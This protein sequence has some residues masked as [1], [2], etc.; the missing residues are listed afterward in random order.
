MFVSEN[1]CHFLE[2]HIELENDEKQEVCLFVLLAH[3][4]PEIYCLLF[5]TFPVSLALLFY[6]FFPHRR[7]ISLHVTNVH[8]SRF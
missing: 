7:R 3:T 2:K 8:Q 5:D 1:S 4:A 6:Y